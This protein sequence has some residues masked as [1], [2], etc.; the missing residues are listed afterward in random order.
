MLKYWV[1]AILIPCCICVLPSVL[2]GPGSWMVIHVEQCVDNEKYP[3]Q[4]VFNRRKVNRTHDGFSGYIYLDRDL[5]ETFGVRVDIC[6]HVDGG[7]KPTAVLEDDCYCNF[8]EK[9]AKENVEDCLINSMGMSPPLCPI[10][11]GN[12][13]ISNYVFNYAEL[14]EQGMYG[15]F[16]VD[17][18]I[19]DGG[20]DIGCVHLTVNFENRDDLV[21][22]G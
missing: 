16:G 9:Y 7:C 12:H 8:A 14:P 22:L 6:K 15:R 1:F 10:P 4:F 21:N 5:D 17:L 19:L 18:Y 13:T 2:V 20:E 11:A 3:F